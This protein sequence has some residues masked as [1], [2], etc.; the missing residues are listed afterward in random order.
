MEILMLQVMR[1]F[2]GGDKGAFM[3]ELPPQLCA[4]DDHADRQFNLPMLQQQREAKHT[5]PCTARRLCH[6]MIAAARNYLRRKA[7]LAGPP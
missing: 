6:R 1:M 7:Q 5:G 2:A 3:A 4:P